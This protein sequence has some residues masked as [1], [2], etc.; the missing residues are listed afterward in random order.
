MSTALPIF[1]EPLSRTG[2]SVG[3]DSQQ[4]VRQADGMVDSYGRRI[5]DLRLSITDRCN[6]RCVYCMEPDVRF[7]PKMQLL[8]VDEFVRL[9]SVCVE[10]GVEKI[11]LTGGEPTLYFGLDELIGRLGELPIKDLALTTNGSLL[12]MP[13]AV[14]WKQAGLKRITISIDSLDPERFNAITRS[15]S[16]PEQVIAAIRTARDAGLEPVRVNAVVVRGQNED[17]IVELAGLARTLG[18]D[19]RLI[20]YMPLDSARAWDQSK[21]VPA[22]EMIEKIQTK[23]LLKD[24]DRDSA[25]SPS[26]VYEFAD[27]AP[28]RI[29]VI[30]SVTRPFC[31]AC[32]RL[33]ITADGKV[34]PCLF[35]REEWDVRGALREGASDD[36]LR[37]IL[38]NATWSKQEGH[39]ISS[40]DY[41]QPD[42]AMWSIG[43]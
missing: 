14:K 27:G 17:E 23:Y 38:L 19:V 4:A 18:V 21:L 29:G 35:S 5:R 15:N 6:F 8:S 12:D 20:E 7:M 40:A 10:L 16:S 43:G 42:R 25:S 2:V 9:A 33:R 22:S 13:R 26:Q 32:S 31:G 1:G 34:R 36:D 41:V 37:A 39:N 30:A 3:D 24:P 28:G 11:R